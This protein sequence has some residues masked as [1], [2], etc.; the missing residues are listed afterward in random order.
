MKLTGAIQEALLS[1]LCYDEERSKLVSTL[2]PATSYDPV[3]SE[4]AAGA[5]EYVDRYDK[6]PGAHTLDI[7]EICCERD[8][9]RA[10]LYRRVF[11]SMESTAGDLN[12]DYVLEQGQGFARFQRVKKGLAG[13]LRELK[14]GTVEGLDQAESEI[15]QA[16]TETMGLFDPGSTLEDPEKALRFLEQYHQP[17][18]CGIKEFDEYGHGPARKR[19]HVFM[20][21]FGVGKS[22]WLVWLAK[23]LL[24]H[25]QRVLYVTLELEEA[26]VMQRLLQA[27]W[28]I[29]KTDA[30]LYVQRFEVDD[31]GRFLGRTA[32]KM[33]DRPTLTDANIRRELTGRM[34]KFS[35]RQRFLCK[36]FPGGELTPKHLEAFLDGLETRHGFIP[37]AVLVDQPDLME[38]DK[39]ATEERHRLNRIY[40]RLRGI[41]Q[42]RSLAMCVVKQANRAG[43]RARQVDADH[44][45]ED[46]NVARHAD[47]LVT[48]SQTDEEKE[49][50]LMRLLLAKGRTAQSRFSVLISQAY[51]IGQFRIDS[52]RMRST[53][54]DTLEDEEE[55]EA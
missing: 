38:S 5:I 19:L 2:V 32:I 20:A 22:W 28:S 15:S 47:V 23:T 54:Y 8:S 7:V 27:L 12:F 51:E 21:A 35:G 46:I 36:E 30:E 25:R 39:R 44:A 48:G 33:K 18:P 43:M 16:I 1:I 6:A 41:A 40:A 49:L 31:D 9:E 53:Y 10:D 42:K 50:G 55:D 24:L 52:A 29:K 17:L 13:A 34:E 3:F 4:I 37:D 26:E 11:E 14:K 45:S